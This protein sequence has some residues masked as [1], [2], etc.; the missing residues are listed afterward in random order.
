MTYPD[1]LVRLAEEAVML[2]DMVLRLVREVIGVPVTSP[3]LPPVVL[4]SPVSPNRFFRRFPGGRDISGVF[5]G[6]DRGNGLESNRDLRL[7]IPWSK[8]IY[9]PLAPHKSST[10]EYLVT[11]KGNLILSYKTFDGAIDLEILETACFIKLFQKANLMIL[12]D[13]LYFVLIFIL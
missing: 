8:Q 10:K 6:V 2:L 13:K 11:V 3:K 12:L 7:F 1:K 5:P 4:A 9:S